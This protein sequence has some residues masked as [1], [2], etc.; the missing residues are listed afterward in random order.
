MSSLA[1]AFPEEERQRFAAENLVI[2]TVIKTFV[3]D[4]NPPKEKRLVIMGES[5]D[6][7][8]LATIYI[9]TDLNLKVFPTQELQDLNPEFLAA[10][11]DYLEHDSHVD[12]T[13]L[14]IMPKQQL[15]NIIGTDP[16]RVLGNLSADDLKQLRDLIK[17][18]KT[19]KPS[20]KKTYGL[21]L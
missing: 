7:I 15:N 4:T 11:R 1:D 20:L 18:A 9:N 12:C 3:A 19:I 17:S 5:F 16:G 2:G 14:H 10:G 6:H 13:A 8:S 21:F